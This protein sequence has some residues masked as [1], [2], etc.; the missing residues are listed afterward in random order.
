MLVIAA[1][2]NII[3]LVKKFT[4]ATKAP[5]WVAQWFP[6]VF[7][8]IGRVRSDLVFRPHRLTALI[9][10]SVLPASCAVLPRLMREAA[11]SERDAGGEKEQCTD[12]VA[13]ASRRPR[14]AF[15]F[16]R[17]AGPILDTE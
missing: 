8:T 12:C 9:A 13:R 17:S 10:H 6:M 7:Y 2:I 16:S 14:R 4:A 3:T 15:R 11:S 1:Q 5:S